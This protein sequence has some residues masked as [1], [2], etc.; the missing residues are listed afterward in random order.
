MPAII[1]VDGM[2]SDL[3]SAPGYCLVEVRKHRREKVN[4]II[5]ESDY[6]SYRIFGIP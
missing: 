5:W 2:I 1:A 6:L 4:L 3:L